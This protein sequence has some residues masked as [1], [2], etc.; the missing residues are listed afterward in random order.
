M[1]RANRVV[2]D[3]ILRL[4]DEKLKARHEAEVLKRKVESLEFELKQ[5]REYGGCEHRCGECDNGLVCVVHDC[6]GSIYFN[7]EQFCEN[8]GGCAEPHDKDPFGPCDACSCKK[9]TSNQR[10]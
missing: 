7:I 3:I 2:E 5:W 4:T 10:R 6:P 9:Q 8:C 1:S